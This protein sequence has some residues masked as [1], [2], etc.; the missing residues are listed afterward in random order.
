M[1]LF[2]AATTKPQIN[3]R[4]NLADPYWALDHLTGTLQ[5]SGRPGTPRVPVIQ[6]QNHRQY[7]LVPSEKRLIQQT[8]NTECNTG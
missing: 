5:A 7:Q 2:P 8:G 6:E 3:R 4:E 1:E